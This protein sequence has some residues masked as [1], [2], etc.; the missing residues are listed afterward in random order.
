MGYQGDIQGWEGW[1]GVSWERSQVVFF[2][3]MRF[4]PQLHGF[5]RELWHLSSLNTLLPLKMEQ[6][7]AKIIW[8]DFRIVW[9]VIPLT[10]VSTRPPS[11]AGVTI[12]PGHH[13]PHLVQK[14]ALMG[15]LCGGSRPQL[16]EL[17]WVLERC[18]SCQR[19][20]P[21]I[22]LSHPLPLPPSPSGRGKAA[23]LIERLI[24]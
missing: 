14:G 24:S 15:M 13:R 17:S 9:A 2:S 11:H 18:N 8:S 3:Q 20:F 16:R 4:C 12:T 6:I 5:I 10:S 7:M 23:M 19:L 1:R 21:A 22:S